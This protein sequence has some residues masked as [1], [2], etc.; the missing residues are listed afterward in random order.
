MTDDTA[1]RQAPPGK[2]TRWR[3]VPADERRA[4]RRALLIRVAFDLLGTEGWHGTTVRRVCHEAQLN[5]RY[6]YES[7]EDLD[8]LLVAVFDDVVQDGFRFGIAVAQE[9]HGR[10]DRARTRHVIEAGVRFLTEDPRRVRVLFVEALGSEKLARRRID[11]MRSFADLLDRDVR[12]RYDGPVDERLSL[13]ASNLLIGGITELL[14]AWL[15]GR[16]DL[17]VEQLVDDI[18]DLTIAVGE[19]AEAIARR[20]LRAARSERPRRAR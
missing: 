2:T 11:T 5:P 16:L 14:M 10:G 15:D 4:E 20:R 13:V 6:F 8:D 18:T 3:G 19:G 7:F 9:P 1:K 17:T 12:A